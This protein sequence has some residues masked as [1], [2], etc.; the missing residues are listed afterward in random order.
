MNEQWPHSFA[1]LDL[2]G[3]NGIK[4]EDIASYA[5]PPGRRDRYTDAGWEKAKRLGVAELS[6]EDFGAVSD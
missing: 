1:E 3:G 5:Y 6:V 4:P 2:E